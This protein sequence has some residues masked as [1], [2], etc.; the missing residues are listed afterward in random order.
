MAVDAGA[1]GELCLTGKNGNLI[2][3]D[4]VEAMATALVDLLDDPEKRK[5][6]GERSVQIAK[7]HDVRVVIPRFVKL[8][9]QVIAENQQSL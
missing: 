9:K 2:P 8:Y 6:Y 3:V 4:D 1:L 5:K 7:K